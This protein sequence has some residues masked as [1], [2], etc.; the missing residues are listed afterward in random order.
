MIPYYN[1]FMKNTNWKILV[2]SGDAD[3]VLNFVSTEQWINSMKMHVQQSWRA[4]Q[5]TDPTNGPQVG[6]WGIV[7]DRMTFKTIKGAG[8]MVPW[9][10]PLPAFSLISTWIKS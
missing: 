10:Q 2:Y 7:F 6:G 4:W 9:T 5:Y 3:T 1:I 8:H